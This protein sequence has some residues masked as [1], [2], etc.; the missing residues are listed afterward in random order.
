MF[1]E[2]FKRGSR[3]ASNRLG[4]SARAVELIMHMRHNAHGSLALV[5][6]SIPCAASICAIRRDH[7]GKENLCFLHAA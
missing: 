6:R 3:S 7:A 1:L 5:K 2:L 4:A